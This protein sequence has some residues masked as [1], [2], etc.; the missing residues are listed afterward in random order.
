MSD[1]LASVVIGGWKRSFAGARKMAE[2]AIEQ[3]DDDQLF[4]RP[5]A[6][7]NSVAAIVKHLA[8]NVKSRWTDWRT[9]DGEKPWRHR[10]SEFDVEGLCRADIDR[11]WAQLWDTIMGELDSMTAEDLG[12]TVTIRSEPHTVPDAVD[13]QLMHMGYHVGQILL[14]ARMVVGSEWQW[15]TI[16]P[17]GS[18]GFNQKMQEQFGPGLGLEKK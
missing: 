4:A 16:K 2:G 9:T 14:I 10:E 18:D 12:R 15:Q 13:R 7:F 5:A 11:L 1:E 17:G 8:G 3:L 6:G